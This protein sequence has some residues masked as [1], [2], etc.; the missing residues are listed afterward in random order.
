MIPLPEALRRETN[1]EKATFL[2]RF[3]KTG[4][5]QYGEGDVFLGLSVPQQRKIA[6]SYT[7]LSL[8]EIQS[9]LKSEIHE[10][11]FTALEILVMKYEKASL[12][13][14]KEIYEFYV[15]N[16]RLVNNWDLVDTSAPHIVGDY[17]LDKKKDV[18]LT[19]ATSD[20]LWEKRIAIVA[21]L[22]LIQAGD[23]TST[24]AI[25]ECLMKDTHDLIHKAC[26][27]MLREVGKRDEAMLESFLKK[28]YKHMPRTMLRYAIERFP[29]PK[30][31]AYLKGEIA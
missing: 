15:K 23:F 30:R 5:G 2:A 8:N 31:K 27:W 10:C 3:F 14:K 19:L 28:H 18:L 11:R 20:N 13:E 9:L 26:G 1:A 25:A 4:K 7:H 29:E 24:F 6:Q 17:V 21:T 16:A 12:P 22:R